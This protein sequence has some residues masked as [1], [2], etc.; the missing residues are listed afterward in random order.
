[1]AEKP[2]EFNAQKRTAERLARGVNFSLALA[3]GDTIA[4][5]SVTAKDESDNDVSASLIASAGHTSTEVT[6]T[7]LPWGTVGSTYYVR[8]VATTTNGEVL[9]RV[10][11]LE[12]TGA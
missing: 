3:T 11:R 2:P 7:F 1:M 9:V 12:I 6:W 5:Q 8:V 10:V 4:S